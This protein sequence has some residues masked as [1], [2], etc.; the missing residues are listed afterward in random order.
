MKVSCSWEAFFFELIIFKKWWCKTVDIGARGKVYPTRD[1]G[2]DELF[3]EYT[4]PLGK[5]RQK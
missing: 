1:K 5:E 4:S 3:P 2:G